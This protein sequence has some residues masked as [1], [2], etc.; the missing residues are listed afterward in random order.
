MTSSSY[1]PA[2]NGFVHLDDLTMREYQDLINILKI[3]LRYTSVMTDSEQE[4]AAS[5]LAI[6]GK[7]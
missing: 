5:I 7:L 1:K 3:A 6:M 4:L 2:G